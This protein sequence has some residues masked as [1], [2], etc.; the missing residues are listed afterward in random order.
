MPIH[1]STQKMHVSTRMSNA[2]AYPNAYMN[3][4]AYLHA[5]VH[6]HVYTHVDLHE[7][8]LA[9]LLLALGLLCDLD[10]LSL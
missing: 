9:L 5:C 4:C 1:M 10:P 7:L 2:H 8:F 3:V 6:T